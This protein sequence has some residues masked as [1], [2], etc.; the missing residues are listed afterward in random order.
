[1]TNL[2]GTI[3]EKLQVDRGDEFD[4][5]Y[6][7]FQKALEKFLNKMFFSKLRHR[8]RGHIIL[9]MGDLLQNRKQRERT[10]FTVE[11]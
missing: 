1:M 3:V 2:L 11:W 7:N 10:I 9:Q 5:A 4:N 6:F 8:M